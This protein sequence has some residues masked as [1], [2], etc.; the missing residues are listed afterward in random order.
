MSTATVAEV[1]YI[2][3]KICFLFSIS[4]SYFLRQTCYKMHLQT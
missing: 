3:W 2:E 4:I 1:L